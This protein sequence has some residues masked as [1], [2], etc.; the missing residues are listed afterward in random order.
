[1]ADVFI[2]YS[3][4]DHA[5]SENLTQILERDG[6]SCWTA[7]RNLTNAY[8]YEEQIPNAIS[9]SK[10]VIFLISRNS[11]KAKGCQAEVA[12]AFDLKKVIIP[13]YLEKMELPVN[14]DFY[15]SHV[16]SIHLYHD[17]EKGLDWVKTAVLDY[18]GKAEGKEDISGNVQENTNPV[19]ENIACQEQDTPRVFISHDSDDAGRVAKYVK[20]LENNGVPCWIAPRD[21][22]YGSN[23]AREIPIAIENSHCFIVFVSKKSQSSEEIEKEIEIANKFGKRIIPAKLDN[24]EFS[25]P[26]MYHLTNKQW[27]NAYCASQEDKAKLIRDL[28]AQDSS[29][30]EKTRKENVQK[31]KKEAQHASGLKKTFRKIKQWYRAQIALTQILILCFAMLVSLLLAVLVDVIVLPVLEVAFGKSFAIILLSILIIWLTTTFISA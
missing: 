15:L 23:Y 5:R 31:N 20:L 2:S 8:N 29:S 30:K 11:I 25:G 18:L 22:P 9:E 16:Q 19:V 13:I 3:R 6:I 7:P 26:Y 24:C 21:I 17:Y 10:L 28:Q 12:F 4:K 27:F 14:L 1:M